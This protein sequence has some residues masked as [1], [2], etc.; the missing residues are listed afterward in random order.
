MASLRV[1]YRSTG[2]TGKDNGKGVIV[3][4][5]VGV[6]GGDGCFGRRGVVF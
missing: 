6:L 1:P 2:S 4:G 3:M 5:G